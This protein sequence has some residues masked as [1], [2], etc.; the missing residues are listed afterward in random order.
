[1]NDVVLPLVKATL[2]Y[3]TDVRDKLLTAIIDG[4]NKELSDTFGLKLLPDNSEHI[5]FVCDLS[6]FRY[7]N[8]GASIM[9]RNLDFRLKNMLIQQA[10][11]ADV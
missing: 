11:V 2:G 6:V 8:Q 3:S 4:V 7:K 5:M 9:P 10:G 1:M